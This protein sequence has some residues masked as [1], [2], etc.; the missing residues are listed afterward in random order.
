MQTENKLNITL[1][2]I[3]KEIIDKKQ[4]LIQAIKGEKGI[5]YPNFNQSNSGELSNWREKNW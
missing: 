3:N 4:E 5:E 1:K 2:K